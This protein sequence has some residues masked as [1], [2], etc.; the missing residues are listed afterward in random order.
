MHLDAKIW[1]PHYW[2]FIH[3]LALSYPDSPN[4][5]LKRKY[6]DFFMNLPLFLPDVEFAKYF[7]TLLDTYP[8]SPYL[9]SKDSLFRWTVFI[10]N[11]INAVLGTQP[12][13]VEEAMDKYY[14]NYE[15]QPTY[16]YKDLKIR[17]YYLHVGFILTV[18]ALS[19]YFA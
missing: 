12:M 2:F 8:V 13:T 5:I 16:L 18:L 19:F 17:R 1:G 14:V 15:P 3:S 6:Y 11:K 10:H 7:S 9:N 4:D